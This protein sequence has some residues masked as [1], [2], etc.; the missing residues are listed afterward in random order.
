MIRPWLRI[1]AVCLSLACVAAS[2]GKHKEPAVLSEAE[3]ASI[4]IS[5]PRPEYPVEARR[6]HITGSG[7]FQMVIDDRGRVKTVRITHSTGS[8]PLDGAA[9][10]A[11]LRWRFKPGL[12]L[13]RANLPITFSL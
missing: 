8:K 12:G 10:Q 7:W 9:V 13:Q 4:V 5:A 1:L 2:R 11:L 6:A 3:L